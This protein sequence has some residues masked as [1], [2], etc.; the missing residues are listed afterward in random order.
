V[1]P[2]DLAALQ[3]VI[4]YRFKDGGLLMEALTHKSF[5]YENPREAP[6]HNERL[7]FLGDSVLSLLTVERL[8]GLEDRYT[9]SE[10]SKVKSFIVK[11]DVLCEVAKEISL[12]GFLML[13]K[14]EE[15]DGGRQ[16]TSILADALE[17]LIGAVYVDGGM[18]AARRLVDGLFGETLREAIRS[19]DYHDYKTE[20]QEECQMRSGLL[21]DYRLT[22]QEGREHEKTFTVE[23]FISG[24]SY[25]RGTG[26]S[27]KEAQ[28]AA[29]REAMERLR[30][31][32]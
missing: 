30:L 6:L 15:D 8:F 22:G 7:E 27:K 3:D 14:G 32:K 9:E 12:G 18:E 13:G 10:M 28:T 17:A 24:E 25:G 16:K 19:G 1:N 5:H 11:G 26:R 31:R 23:V 20:L 21:P 29:A 2:S 4:G